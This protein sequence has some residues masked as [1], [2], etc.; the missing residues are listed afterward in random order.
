M[1]DIIKNKYEM[2]SADK[3]GLD[4]LYHVFYKIYSLRQI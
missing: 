3:W 4:P 2:Y 1:N